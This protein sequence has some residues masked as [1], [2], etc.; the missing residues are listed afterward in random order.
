M[1]CDGREAYVKSAKATTTNAEGLMQRKHVI[2]RYVTAFIANAVLGEKKSV[3]DLA[4]VSH[5]ESRTKV[6]ASG[7]VDGG[8]LPIR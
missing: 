3:G 4:D 6:S 8:R 1:S 7:T 5:T 2:V